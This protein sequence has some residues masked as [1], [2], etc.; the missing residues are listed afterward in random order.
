[1]RERDLAIAW[2]AVAVVFLVVFFFEV[3]WWRAVSTRAN[4]VDAER[5][6]LAA[7]IKQREQELIAEAR[8]N[9]QLLQ[10]MSWTATGADPAAFIR[11]VADLA[12]GSRLKVTAIGSIE[13]QSTPQFSKSWH[14]IEISGPY[15]ELRGL[16]ARV[17]SERGVLEN[18]SFVEAP[19]EGP[20]GAAQPREGRPLGA[21]TETEVLAKFRM[22]SME[23]TPKTRDILNQ[24]SQQSGIQL[25]PSAP[26]AGPAVGLPVPVT[27]VA[28]GTPPARDPFVFGIE[29]TVRPVV[30]AGPKGELELQGIV[31]FPGGYLAIV[32]NT[33]V[34]VGDKVRGHRVEDITDRV[35]LLRQP[36][37]APRRLTLPDI[38]VPAPAG[39]ARPP[40]PSEPQPP[41]Q[42]PQPGPPSQGPRR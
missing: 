7:A 26:P 8:A 16:A 14:S 42:P 11:R 22:A 34:K 38:A 23:L 5:I 13:R 36:N 39:S 35:V 31:G 40:G 25:T 28:A 1:M 6:K 32:D 27:P 10:E 2:V 41:V 12:Q 19:R 4:E 18:V 29:P 30:A 3:S 15:H 21:L 24:A 33:I 17:E 9:A 37:G 20:P